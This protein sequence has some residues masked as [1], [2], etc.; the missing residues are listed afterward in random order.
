M[1]PTLGAPI[2]FVVQPPSHPILH[3]GNF[4]VGAKPVVPPFA[5]NVYLTLLQGEGDEAKA[6]ESYVVPFHG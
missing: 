4:L 1:H 5:F 2:E 6:V 3:S